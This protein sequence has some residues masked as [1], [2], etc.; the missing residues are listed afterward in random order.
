MAPTDQVE[1]HPA[2]MWDCPHCGQENFCRCVTY[3][4]GTVDLPE[5]EEEGHWVT[6]PEIVQCSSCGNRYRTKDQRSP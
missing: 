4:P 1:L 3:E 2:H 5:E 6:A